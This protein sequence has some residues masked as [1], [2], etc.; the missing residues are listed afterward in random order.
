MVTKRPI[1][2]SCADLFKRKNVYVFTSSFFILQV[3]FLRLI[4]HKSA[5]L[6][7]GIWGR[8]EHKA[9]F[10]CFQPPVLSGV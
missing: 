2:I 9:V 3:R 10:L 1:S 6:Q 8:G 4:V 7:H 5:K